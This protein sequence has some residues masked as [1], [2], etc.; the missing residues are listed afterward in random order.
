[1]SAYPAV[2]RNLI[3][4]YNREHLFFGYHSTVSGRADLSR[5]A[6]HQRVAAQ[7][8]ATQPV[9]GEPDAMFGSRP[10]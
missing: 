7:A 5:E 1:M 3:L 4:G 10:E 2:R 9:T 8:R 6:A